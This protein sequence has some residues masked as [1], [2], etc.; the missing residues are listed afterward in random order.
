MIPM[1]A[2]GIVLLP[3]A[4]ISNNSFGQQR[5]DCPFRQ[6]THL[7]VGCNELADRRVADGHWDAAIG[8]KECVKPLGDTYPVLTDTLRIPG[9]NDLFL[10]TGLLSFVS[11]A[12]R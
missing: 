7:D 4:V 11:R 9:Q 5:L 12:L 2:V 3:A 8:S 10:R 6:T 1:P